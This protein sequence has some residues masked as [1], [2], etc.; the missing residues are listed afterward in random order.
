MLSA[1]KQSGRVRDVR[2]MSGHSAVEEEIASL[3]QIAFRTPLPRRHADVDH[4]SGQRLRSRRWPHPAVEKPRVE[5]N[6]GA[7]GAADGAE[8]ALAL[9]IEKR[10]VFFVLQLPP[11][12]AVSCEAEAMRKGCVV[13]VAA[14]QKSERRRTL[15]HVVSR[16]PRLHAVMTWILLGI[17]ALVSV[18]P[19]LRGGLRRDGIAV[20]KKH[21]HS[22]K[23]RDQLCWW[24]LMDDR[25]RLADF[26]VAANVPRVPC[27]PNAPVSNHE[28]VRR[29]QL[30]NVLPRLLLLTIDRR[31]S[32]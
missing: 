10:K 11:V 15:H 18:Q 29:F 21:T 2:D 23:T 28:T 12:G 16:H 27:M 30:L 24:R 20:R 26:F 3:A 31:G 9:T 13:L 8:I 19:Q 14:F 6:H 1:R 4:V 7:R 22:V 32:S 5:E 17:E 25:E